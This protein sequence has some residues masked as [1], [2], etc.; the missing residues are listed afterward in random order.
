MRGVVWE[1]IKLHTP[2]LNFQAAEE[3][4]QIQQILLL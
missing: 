2:F 3:Q 1:G 4:E